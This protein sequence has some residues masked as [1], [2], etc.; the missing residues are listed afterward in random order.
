[1]E[2]S[3]DMELM[4]GDSVRPRAGLVSLI[5]IVVA[6]TLITA[7]PGPAEAN[8]VRKQIREA[9]RNLIDFEKDLSATVKT[10]HRLEDEL[11]AA[12]K[13]I[14]S[15]ERLL[16]KL[17]RASSL[18]QALASVLVEPAARARLEMASSQKEILLD[19]IPEMRDHIWQKGLE[20]KDLIETLDDAI[21]VLESHKSGT[22]VT[23]AGVDGGQLITYSADWAAVAM[24]ESTNRWHINT[25]LFDGG[26]QFLPSTWWGF[27]GGE[28]ARYAYQATR[29]QQIDIAER[30][31]AVQG[32]NAW[33]NCFKALP[34]DTDE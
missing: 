21:A 7:A 33:P 34:A 2:K 4:L 22:L 27:G 17:E 13:M 9:K 32:P 19:V 16:G 1:M 15:E 25:G 8:L 23:K 29:R 14:R 11:E 12:K 26:L 24:C 18:E 28:Y 10:F 31:L 6:V 20:R 5:G 3:D 30:V